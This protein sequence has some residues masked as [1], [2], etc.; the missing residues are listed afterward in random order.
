MSQVVA[1]IHLRKRRFFWPALVVACAM[2][3]LNM[4]DDDSAA[5]WLAVHALVAELR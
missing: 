5:E 3:K 2:V 1:T 4:I